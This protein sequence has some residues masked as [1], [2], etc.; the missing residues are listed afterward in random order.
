MIRWL[1][2][3]LCALA[4]NAQEVHLQVLTTTDLQGH[5]LPQDSFTLQPANQGWARLATLVRAL[6][7]ANPNTVLVDCGGATRGEP[8]NYVWSQLNRKLPE[9]SMAIMNSLGYNAMV[10]GRQEF[11]SGLQQVRA[12]EDQ[13]QFPWLAANVMFT[14]GGR[15]VFTPYVKLD[16]GGVQ[17]AV[18]GLASAVNPVGSDDLTFQDPV[19]DAKI[20]IPLLREQEKVDLVIV[21]LNG[22][23]GK[24]PCADP[25]NQALCLAT[26][27]SGIDLILAGRSGQMVS[28][29]ANGVPILQAGTRG[30]AVGVA[31]LVFRRAR[32]GRWEL[33]SH[34]IRIQQPGPETANDP[35]VLEL[36]APLRA[37]TETYLNTFAT[38]LG[39]DLD[40]RWSRMEDTPLMHLLHTVA[41]QASGAQI[42]ALATPGARIF[43]PKGVTSVRQFYALH[44]DDERIDRIRVTGRQLRAYLEHAARFYNFSHNP[45][46]FAKGTGPGDFDTLDGCTYA[47]DISRPA[48]TRVVDLKFQGQPVKDDQTFT[49]GLPAGR[50]SGTGGYLEAM[51]WS[52]RPEF[53]SRAPFRNLLLEYV[54]SRP[55]LAP[56]SED[57]WRIIPALDRERVQAQQP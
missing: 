9:P 24:E 49:L 5:V 7:A 42:T 30:Q 44:P 41:R 37:A 50:L 40:G 10:V 53:Q 6:R 19:I 56:A 18:V 33:V 27:V 3:L 51:G 57:N 55:T 4:M 52:G 23:L 21:A 39:T 38:N 8:I 35:Q 22:G 48:G 25:E 32:R 47:L 31:D 1:G 14:A 12:L 45:E 36:T 13:A 17:V 16:V 54:L 26:Q 46:L 15:R 43:I 34:R 29:E 28:T 11:D 20:L 2:I